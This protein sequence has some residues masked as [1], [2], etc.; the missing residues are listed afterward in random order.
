MGKLVAQRQSSTDDLRQLA[1]RLVVGRLP[2]LELD[3]DHKQALQEGTIG[4][5]TLFK[6]NVSDLEQLARVCGEIIE[7]SH[8]IPVLTVDQEG[9]AVQRFDHAIS[10]LPSPMALAALNKSE[11]NPDKKIVEKITAI[12]ARQ[13]KTLG[14]NMLLSPTLDLQTNPKNPIICTRAYGDD[15]KAVADIGGRIATEIEAQGLIAVGKH[16]PGHGSTSEDSHLSIATVD[17]SEAAL[18]A[19]DLVPFAKLK[20]QLRAILVGHIW[21]PQLVSKK[22]PATVCPEIVTEL[23]QEKMGFKGL[24]VSDDMIMKAITEGMGLGEACVQAVIAGE[25]LLLIC[26]TFA[27]S[28]ESVDALVEATISGRLTKERLLEANA[29]IDALFNERQ[30]YLK[31]SDFSALSK[32]AGEVSIDSTLSAATSAQAIAVIKS[33]E[34]SKSAAALVG[35]AKIISIVAPAHFRYPMNLYANL[36]RLMAEDIDI[37][38]IRYQVNPPPE[39]LSDIADQCSG[40]I[41]YVTYRSAINDGQKALGLCL[42]AR[43]KDADVNSTIIH[44]ASDSPYDI[45]FMPGF[46]NF[47]SLATFDP[48]D[49]AIAGLARVLTG[50]AEALGVCPVN[51]N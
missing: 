34:D 50:D 19:S 22:S 14:F 10:P 43:C 44:V 41:I 47:V 39:L 15:P 45:T 36:R 37:H 49:R 5:I 21:L 25:D 51:L 4:G 28:M 9:G 16:F 11:K 46:E 17:K 7:A 33:S 42:A 3:D 8:H 20:D 35:S 30:D 26:G 48:S 27:Q 1:G 18:E 23:L 31:V 24:V 13:L 2:G 29:K 6:D 32:F 40:L 12:S 38:D